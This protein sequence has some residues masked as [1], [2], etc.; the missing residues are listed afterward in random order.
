MGICV[1][2]LGTEYRVLPASAVEEKYVHYCNMPSS[3]LTALELGVLLTRQIQKA[4]TNSPATNPFL[5]LSPLV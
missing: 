3:S 4:R 5:K 2:P 1:A